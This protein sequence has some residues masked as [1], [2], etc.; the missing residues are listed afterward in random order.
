MR[1]SV[2]LVDADGAIVDT[3]IVAEV[4]LGDLELAVARGSNEIA[5]DEFG[6]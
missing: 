4:G 6:A 2:G 3:Q 5:V 1:R